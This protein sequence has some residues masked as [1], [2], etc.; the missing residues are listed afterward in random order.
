MTDDMKILMEKDWDGHVFPIGGLYDI[1]VEVAEYFG[2]ITERGDFDYLGTIYRNLTDVAR[3]IED[4][5]VFTFNFVAEGDDRDPDEDQNYWIL[6]VSPEGRYLL[7]RLYDAI[8]P[9]PSDYCGL[10]DE[11]KINS[12]LSAGVHPYEPWIEDEPFAKVLNS[13]DNP[14]TKK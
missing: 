7:V 5:N 8:W 6:Y 14:P 4:G 3:F 2:L 13:V 12:I 10:L 11:V 1:S 9:P